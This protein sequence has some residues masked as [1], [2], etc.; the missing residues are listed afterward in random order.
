MSLPNDLSQKSV[1]LNNNQNIGSQNKNQDLRMP[2]SA[3]FGKEKEGIKTEEKALEEIRKSL[4]IEIDKEV[5]EAG[6]KEIKGT[7]ELPQKVIR[8]TGIKEVG[9]EVPLPVKPTIKLPLDG[10]QIKKA[11]KQNKIIDSILWL[12]HWCLRQIK[13]AQFKALKLVGFKKPFSS[14]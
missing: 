12:A 3:G 11:I 8:E 5:K 1:P 7:V 6:V 4:E 13:I 9:E 10:V 14:S 2:V